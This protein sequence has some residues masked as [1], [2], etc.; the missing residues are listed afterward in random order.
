MPRGVTPR[1]VLC[2]SSRE[3]AKA[4]NMATAKKRVHLSIDKKVEVIKYAADHPGVGVRAIGEQ[5]KIGKTQV[6]D[7]LKNKD[8]IQT[9]FESN[10]ATHQKPRNS[11]FSSV[12]EALYE[13][14]RMACA[15]NIYP[16]G[17]QL[18][19]KAKEIATRL[20]IDGFE[21]SSGW[22]TKWKGRYNIKKIRVCGESGDVAGETIS[23]W[24]ERLP[25][26]LQGYKAEDIFNLD[27]TGCFWRA[28]PESGFG[29]RGKKHSGGKKSKKRIT[30]A[31]VVS[32]TGVK[33]T[34]IVIWNSKSPRCFRG[35]DVRS[36]PVKYYSQSK[37]WMTG[38][39]LVDYLTSFN[40][41]MRAE[42]R[43][44]LLLLDNAGCHPPEMLQDKFSNIKILFVPPNTTS[45][46]QPLDLG[47]IANF[48][49]HYKRLFLQ[50]VLARIDEAKNATE[51]TG[52]INVLTAIRLVALG[53]REV[54]ASTIKKCFSKAGVLR[55][56][57]EVQVVSEEED[58]FVDIDDTLQLG[59]LIRS[60]M[61][62]SSCSAEEYLTG[63]DAL[64]VCAD[65][66]CEDWDENWLNSLNDNP[67]SDTGDNPDSDTGDTEEVDYDLLPPPPKLTCFK[68][69]IEAL[70]D[71]QVFLKYQGYVEQA[72]KK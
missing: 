7:I 21:G 23:S 33:E 47:I 39:I 19:A 12:N 18:I 11:K 16:S 42:K 9:A 59:P 53:W 26:L 51:V 8:S 61:G 49:V 41:K 4:F 54:K 68:Q 69:A 48:K 63:E 71:V 15:K 29:E 44:V 58:P 70:E 30:I 57:F 24:K 52:S 25:E 45:K 67:D 32:A 36:L 50:H 22:L 62:G 5:F 64:P 46:L 27:E 20:G 72:R 60:A 13:W 6:S 43:S 35:F 34:P 14:F 10:L 17:P 3:L 66:D 56:D 31:F 2:R 28:L 55:D 38:E 40:Q 1:C 65:F 37:S